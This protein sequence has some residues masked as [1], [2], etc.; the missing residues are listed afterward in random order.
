MFPKPLSWIPSDIAPVPGNRLR[1]LTLIAAALAM[2]IPARMRAQSAPTAGAPLPTFE[3]VSI[4][5]NHSGSGGYAMHRV[6]ASGFKMINLNT[7]FLIEFAYGRSAIPPYDALR[8]SQLVGGPGWI[9][10]DQYDVEAK[11]DDSLAE[12]FAKAPHEKPYFRNPNQDVTYQIQLMMQSMLVE[13]FKLKVHREM[14]EGPIFALVVA[15]GGPKFLNTKFPELDATLR[16]TGQP[17]AHPPHLPCTPG[18][19]CMVRRMSMSELAYTLWDFGDHGMV[20]EIG[21]PVIDQTGIKGDYDIQLQWAPEFRQGAILMG[22]N[23]GNPG[24]APPESAGPSFLTAL[25][26]QLGLKLEPTKGPVE[27]VVVDHVERPTEN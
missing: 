15:K 25:Q 4:K 20:A 22:P 21:R 24:G 19:A 14:R 12:K 18:L 10:T 13:R 27:Y 8:P 9:K 6:T 5:P 2:A 3:V 23:A 1:R 7:R 16:D 11:V 26:E 17:P